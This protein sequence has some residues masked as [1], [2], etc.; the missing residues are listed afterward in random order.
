MDHKT[1]MIYGAYGYTGR[2]VVR[3]ALAR[4]RRPILAGRDAA[5]LEATA[6]EYQLPSRAFDV[7]DA[8][9]HLDGVDLVLNCAGP[10]TSTAEP[11]MDACL[12][13]GV[14]YLDITGEIPVFKAA[15]RRHQAAVDA[16]VVLCPGVGFDVVPT[17]CLAALLKQSLPEATHLELAF[18]FGS[19]PSLGTVRTAMRGIGAGCLIREDS[20]LKQVRHGYRIRKIPFPRGEFWAVS[21]AW[22]DVFTSQI[23]TGIPNAIVYGAMSRSACWAMRLANPIRGILARPLGQRVLLW[24]AKRWLAGGSDEAARREARSGFWGRVTSEDGRERVGT[25]SGPSAYLMTAELAVAIG[26]EVGRGE[27]QGGYYT[28]SMLVGAEFLVGREGYEVKVE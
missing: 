6:E 26:G 3:E 19:L 28:A 15:H 9:E 14:H 20:K 25:I 17:D 11:M 12:A 23:S 8:A 7:G 1:W 18:E 13:R 10:F 16:G 5:K 24:L 21:L 27:K 4:G 22:G 2:L